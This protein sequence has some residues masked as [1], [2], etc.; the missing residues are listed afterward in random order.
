MGIAFHEG[1]R[2][3]S[4]EYYYKLAI[5]HSPDLSKTYVNLAV[6]YD[7]QGKTTAALGKLEEAIDVNPRDLLALCHAALTHFQIKH[8]DRAAE[9]ISRAMEIDPDH[10]QPHFYQAI[11]F[12]ESG[13]YREAVKE[14][15]KVIELDPEGML[16]G[17]A[18]ENIMMVQN[19]MRNAGDR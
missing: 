7:S 16:A 13:I 11:F 14:W 5:E 19:A 6:L 2:P 1:S 4:A 9:Y 3:D 17:K 15:E 8:Y 12:W 10:P 18:K